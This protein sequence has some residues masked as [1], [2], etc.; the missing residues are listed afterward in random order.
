MYA[1]IKTGGKQYKVSEGDTLEIEK[2]S[3]EEGKEVLFDQV[4]LFD[5]GKDIK[6]GKPIVEGVAV[7]GKI[8]EHGKGEK[9]VVFKYKPKK[10]FR[11]KKG[12]RQPY[13]KVEIKEISSK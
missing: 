6:I 11:Q 1:V 4:L 12:H 5:D 9:K 7:K 2:L 13:T 3:E 10:R 8:L